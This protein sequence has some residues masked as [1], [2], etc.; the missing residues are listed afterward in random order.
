MTEHLAFSHWLA[1]FIDGE[2]CFR[3]ALNKAGTFVVSFT[4]RLRR[5]DESILYEIRDFL[6][7][8]KVYQEKDYG[9]SGCPVSFF[10]ISSIAGCLRL[11]EV[12]DGAPMRAKKKRDFEIWKEAIRHMH[13]TRGGRGRDTK[14]MK[15]L[16]DALKAQRAFSEQKR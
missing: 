8:G 1:G 3:F 5:D 7:C 16:V 13:A 2:G 6:G 11:V 9:A 4:I 14:R 15:E 12:L 10:C